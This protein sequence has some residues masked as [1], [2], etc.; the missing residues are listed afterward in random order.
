[1][2]GKPLIAFMILALTLAPFT[3]IVTLS[4]GSVPVWAR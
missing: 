2:V 1:M 3:L 4:P